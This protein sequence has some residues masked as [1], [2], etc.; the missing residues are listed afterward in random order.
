MTP[1]Y[2]DYRDV[3]ITQCDRAGISLHANVVTGV[4]FEP[5]S[6][7][8]PCDVSTHEALEC[9]VL[10]V[11]MLFIFQYYK[12]SLIMVSRRLRP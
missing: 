10:R 4:Y 2:V 7:L 1:N 3:V 6:S 8:S 5:A 9:L 12:R 11:Y